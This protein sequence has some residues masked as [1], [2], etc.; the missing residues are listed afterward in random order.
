METLEQY[1]AWLFEEAIPAGGLGPR[2]GPRLWERHIGDSVAFA[3]ALGSEVG[4]RVLDVGSGVGLPGIPL[5]VTLPRAE[6]ILLDR[7]GRRTRLL[8]R[9]LRILDLPNVSVVQGDV[10]RIDGRYD[11][12]VSRGSLPQKQLVAQVARLV[13]PGGIGVVALSRRQERPEGLENLMRLADDLGIDAEVL[14]V[15]REVL[16]APSWLLRL[17]PRGD[18]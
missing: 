4:G 9:A 6:F 15:P 2:E 11:G 14:C 8:N 10:F 17:Q 12:L 1:A 7:A 5:A 16:D 3:A 18:S 13:A